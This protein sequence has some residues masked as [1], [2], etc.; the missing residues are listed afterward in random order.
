M[1]SYKST[2][3]IT[4]LVTIFCVSQIL[5]LGNYS[6]EPVTYNITE[7]II[8]SGVLQDSIREVIPSC[9]YV[10]V[11]SLYDNYWQPSSWSGSGVIVS[12]NGIIITAAHVVKDATKIRVT[13]NDGRVFE[14]EGFEYETVTDVGIIKINVADLPIVPLANPANNVLG[15]PVFIIGCPFGEELFNTVTSGIVS[16]LKRDVPFFGE[17]LMLQVDAGSAPGNSG[18]GVF[19][20]NGELTGI[21]VGGMPGYGHISI[22]VPSDVLTYVLDNYCSEQNLINVE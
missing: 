8:G 22:C 15:D 7:N 3:R 9:V 17:K 18:G 4:L 10:E 5:P 11:E 1:L 2:I 21:L 13:L 6:R 20:M 16:G 12:S 14:A 19:N